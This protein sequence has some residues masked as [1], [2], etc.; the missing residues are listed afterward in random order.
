M[1]CTRVDVYL[2]V[3]RAVMVERIERSVDSLPGV[4]SAS[5]TRWRKMAWQILGSARLPAEPEPRPVDPSSSPSHGVIDA[6]LEG[7]RKVPRKQRHTAKRIFE[8]LR[9]EYGFTG[10]VHHSQ[11]LTSAEVSRAARTRDVRAV[12]PPAGPCA[13]RFRRGDGGDQGV[14]SAR[15]TTSVLGPAITAT[16]AL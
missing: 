14:W 7:D 16:A 11:G 2:R 4:R 13:V 6:I 8:R 1:D 3:R 9:D 15:F 12:V 10:L 5:A